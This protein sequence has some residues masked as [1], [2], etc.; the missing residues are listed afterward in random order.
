MTSLSR[1]QA[2]GRV[3]SVGVGALAVLGNPFGYGSVEAQSG[4]VQPIPPSVDPRFPMPST[5]ERELREIAPNVYAYIQGGG[6]GRNYFSVSDAGLIIGD[7]GLT[8]VD[9]LAAPVHTRASS[10]RFARSPTNPSDMSSSRITTATTSTALST[11]RE[12]RSSATRTAGM[13]SSRSRTAARPCG[14]DAKGG[15]TVQSRDGSCRRR[16]PSMAR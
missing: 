6:P 16:P 12:Q 2:I 10:R 3:A 4:G 11:S 8:I 15:R 9:T 7:N 13:K 5:W 14:N 1:R